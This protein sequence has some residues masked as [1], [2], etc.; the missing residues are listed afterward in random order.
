MIQRFDIAVIGADTPVAA[1][2]LDLMADRRF[3]AGEISALVE[4]PDEAAPVSFAGGELDVEDLATYEYAG[5]QLAFLTA[6]SDAAL[7]AAE[8]A[9]DAGCVVVDATGV[10]WPDPEIPVVVAAHNPQALERFNE[11]GIVA[12]PDPL[13]VPLLMTLAP[14]HQHA[15]LRRLHVTA[16]IPASDAGRVGLEDLARQTTALLNARFYESRAFPHQI[17][18]NLMGQ[19][20]AADADG[21][22]ER[23]R[24]VAAQ[25]STALGI[26]SDVI[27]VTLL[28]GALF[29]G[30]GLSVDVEFERSIVSVAE[31]LA[32]AASVEVVTDLDPAQCPSPVSHALGADTV[33]V[34]RL[35]HPAARQDRLTFWATADNIRLG[36]ALN[37]VMNAES[38]IRDYL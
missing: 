31:L 22:T 24:Q 2:V 33:C 4:A 10:V 30:Y 1:A 19:V 27:S 37:A 23:E 34:A 29:Y 17:A 35:R 21:V 15:V 16:V 26:V 20:G 3:P 12:N 11:R 25:V 14:L 32:E 8:R 13:V 28:Q 36:A 7:A 9:A 38:L 18:F 5:V 6:R